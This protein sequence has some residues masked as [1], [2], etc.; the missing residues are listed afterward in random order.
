MQEK[1]RKTW[2]SGNQKSVE[3]TFPVTMLPF[4]TVTLPQLGEITAK[5]PVAVQAQKRCLGLDHP[6]HVLSPIIFGA[7]FRTKQ[8]SSI[9][10]TDREH[11]PSIFA[12]L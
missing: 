12:A 5:V 10:P 11:A 7:V 6:D 3:Q 9:P 8:R 1:P 4:A 2:S